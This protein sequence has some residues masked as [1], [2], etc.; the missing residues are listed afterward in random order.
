M[1][2]CHMAPYEECT[3]H[4]IHVVWHDTWKI[5]HESERKFSLLDHTKKNQFVEERRKA[6]KKKKGEEN[7]KRGERKKSVW[8][9]GKR[10]KKGKGREGRR[11]TGSSSL[12][13]SV[14]AEN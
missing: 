11:R 4:E 7:K 12:N 1:K 5:D 13:F 8:E 14:F 2:W 9:E 6:E 10:E 3:W